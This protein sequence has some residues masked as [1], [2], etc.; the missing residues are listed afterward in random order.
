MMMLSITSSS[1]ITLPKS[2]LFFNKTRKP[3]LFLPHPTL[4]IKTVPSAAY[5]VLTIDLSMI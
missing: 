5:I 2:F 4:I 3:F 1:A